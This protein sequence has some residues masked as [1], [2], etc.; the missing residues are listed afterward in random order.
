MI[1]SSESYKKAIVADYRRIKP[2]AIVDIISPDVEYGEVYGI[3]APYSNKNQVSDGIFKNEKNFI[4]L[5]HNRW[6]LDGTMILTDNAPQ[7]EQ[8]GVVTDNMS[9]ENGVM[10]ES[11]ELSISGVS[12]LQNCMIFF[13]TSAMDGVPEDFKV[14][15]LQ[16]GTAYHTEEFTGNIE[17]SVIVSGFEVN[18]AD[19]IRVTV[20][21]TRIPYRRVRIIEIY[22][23]IH[24][25][26][27]DDD[28]SS[29][30]IKHQGDSSTMSVPYGT[31]T[32]GID[33]SDLR[34]E[35]RNKQGIFKSIEE[36]QNIDIFY[37]VHTEYGIERKPVGVFYQYAGGWKTSQNAMT[38]KWS[39]VDI[40][41]L[42]A[43]R[44]YIAPAQLPI[45]LDGWVQSIV[46]QLGENFSTRYIV[47]PD[48]ASISLTTTADKVEEKNCGE[49]LTDLCMVTGTWA[50]ADA[51]TGKL[52]VEPLWSQGNE[53]T[54]DNMEGYPEIKAN[55]DV[56]T[57]TFTLNDGN[58]TK[59]TISGNSSA[60]SNSLSVENPFIKDEATALKAARFI[61]QS[62]GGDEYEI[63]YRG[64]PSSEIGDVQTIQID[65]SSAVS[66]RLQEHSLSF[67]D[68]VL[69]G[70]DARLIQPTG[71]M[72][73]ENCV[74][75]TE[76]G[77]FQAESGIDKLR[78]ILVEGG[79]GG[80]DG[81]DGSWSSAGKD[82]INGLG[83]KVFF[84]EIIIND[85]QIFDVQIGTGGE[86]G[87]YGTETIFGA[88]SSADGQ[89]YDPSYTD[90]TNGNTYGRTGVKN[91]IDGYGDGGAGGAGGRK[92]NRHTE[93]TTN[94]DG[95]TST[96]TVIDNRP[97]DGEKGYKGASGCAV[98]YWN[99]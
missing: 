54:L 21:K 26:W 15:I 10:N 36:R 41:G 9:D 28:I 93:S 94:E 34:F 89:R 4:T 2:Y 47:D 67:N 79:A 53:I 5:E 46:S 56:A 22:P 75:I 27:D 58:E 43:E 57:I 37:D 14:E 66:A 96:K 55:D 11:V 63:K 70:C 74:I 95:S 88:Y 30:E 7:T 99:S 39:L 92:G 13:S 44:R 71:S 16:G 1:K 49:L 61:L 78:I 60:S 33:N 20:T 64:D 90:I 80:T 6:I 24:E 81:E 35:Y 91:P 69:T 51:E 65:E 40:I 52:T 3:L 85:S 62:Y 98:V 19:A 59:Y 73:F 86:K 77:R 8:V 50:R 38:I 68:G 31:C 82:G 76:S 48:Y 45:T 84:S 23:G 12:V 72:I 25:E 29:L 83:G 42:L 87:E 17:T 32:L 97:G 18:N